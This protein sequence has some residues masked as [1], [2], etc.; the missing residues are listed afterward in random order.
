M[1]WHISPRAGMQGCSGGLAEQ[2]WQ[3]KLGFSH[4]PAI[5]TSALVRQIDLLMALR[6]HRIYHKFALITDPRRSC[7]AAAWRAGWTESTCNRHSGSLDIGA[8][9]AQ[10]QSN[11]HCNSGI[12]GSN[13]Q[14]RFCSIW[15]PLHFPQFSASLC[16][17]HKIL[18]MTFAWRAFS[19]RIACVEPGDMMTFLNVGMSTGT[20]LMGCH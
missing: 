8:S 4:Q 10:A 12:R 20:C 7:R 14:W 1:S 15:H 13:S 17:L 3:H 9:T 19:S 11:R 2:H 6:L 18:L 16:L 5:N